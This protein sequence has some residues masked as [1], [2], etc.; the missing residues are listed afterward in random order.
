M[1]KLIREM[2]DGDRYDRAFTHLT[3]TPVLLRSYVRGNPAHSA[4]LS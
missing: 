1:I 3:G 4:P 2:G